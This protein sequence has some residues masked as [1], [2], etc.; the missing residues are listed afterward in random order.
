MYARSMSD[1]RLLSLDATNI[2]GLFSNLASVE[3]HLAKYLPHI[4]F[5]SETQVSDHSSSL[6][7]SSYSLQAKFRY[8]GGVC[9]YIHSCT[10]ASRLQELELKEYD[11]LWLKISLPE[12]TVVICFTYCSP[13]ATNYERFFNYLS[14][15]H[16]TVISKFPKAEIIYMGDF[17]VHHRTWLGSSTTDVGGNE[18]LSFSI[19]NDLHQIINQPTH[20]PD[21]SGDA[22]NILDLLFVTSPS[23]FQF[24]VTSPLGSS[25]H[26]LIKTSFNSIC[27]LTA[28]PVQRKLWHY[29]RANWHGMNDFF[30]NNDWSTC[31]IDD[32]ASEAASNVT[33][34]INT[35]MQNF[36]PSSTKTIVNHCSWHNQ[37]CSQATSKKEEA[38]RSWKR[39]PSDENHFKYIT[40]RNKCKSTLRRTKRAFIKSK[41]NDLASSFSDKAF[42]SLFTE[43][44]NNF[45][46][47]SF[48]PLCCSNGTVVSSPAEKAN[49]FGLQFKENSTIDLSNAPIPQTLPLSNQMAPL[50]IHYDLV[51]LVLIGLKT[52]KASGPD[53]ISP[54]ILKE[55]ASSLAT[56]LVRLYRLCMVTKTFPTCWKLSLIHPIPKKGDKSDPS[57]YR[58]IS[59]TSILAKVFESL[60]NSHFLSHLE[61]LHLLSDHQYGFRKARSTGD[62]LAYLSDIWLS[63]L[64]NRGKTC[65]VDLDISKA[66]DRIWHAALISKLPAYGFPPSLCTFISSYLSNRSILAVVY[67][68][69]FKEFNTNSVVSQGA[70]LSPTLFSFL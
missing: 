22:A 32:D 4:L 26:C 69:R 17:N 50:N 38:Y 19:T 9:A 42:W 15:C 2:R 25:D 18:A 58:P 41:C 6:N 64:K 1:N 48:P 61:S 23:R 24:E 59:L 51:R 33:S 36:I 7:I 55:C 60:L 31:F 27:H 70:V 45:C 20:I 5:L 53:G 46:R 52:N 35:A 8:K 39:S 13:N 10:P 57:N 3:S 43:V 11:A 65:K 44:S 68:A 14:E 63:H 40:A 16:D 49:V 47:S 37:A 28:P 21:R 29:D 54:R 66:F 62:I 30:Y 12:N 67:G 56:P 34:V